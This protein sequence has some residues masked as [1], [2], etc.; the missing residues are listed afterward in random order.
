MRVA[1][2]VPDY[3]PSAAPAKVG[4]WLADVGDDVAVGDR[5]VELL[6]PGLVWNVELPADGRLGEPLLMM[7][8]VVFPGDILGWVD[9]AE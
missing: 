8:T 4:A 7:G 1:I 2:S 3:G 6:L 5:V 9:V